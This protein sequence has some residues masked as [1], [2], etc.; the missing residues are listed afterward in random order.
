MALKAYLNGSMKRITKHQMVTFIGGVKKRIPKGVTFVNGQ[1]VVLWQV[2]NFEFNSWTFTELQCPVT[3]SYSTIYNAL[4]VNDTKIVYNIEKNIIRANI[5][6]VSS[7]YNENSVQY[8]LITYRQ[9]KSNSTNTYY[10]SNVRTTENINGTKYVLTCN[11]IDIALSD[12]SITATQT[13]RSTKTPTSTPVVIQSGYYTGLINVGGNYGMVRIYDN[14]TQFIIYK[15]FSLNSQTTVA[16]INLYGYSVSNV[17]NS[18]KGYVVY[19]GRY[20]L[21]PCFYK[22]T[23]DSDKVYSLKRIDLS[24]GNVITLID[25]ATTPITGI[26]IDGTNILVTVGSQM[27]KINISG[28]ELTTAYTSPNDLP[29]IV[30]KYGNYYYLT[31]TRAE[32]DADYM[33]IE[34]VDE[35]DFTSGEVKQTNVKM[36]ETLTMPYISENGYICFGSKFYVKTYGSGSGTV[37]P[38]ASRRA[39]TGFGIGITGTTVN[40]SNVEL[41]ICRIKCY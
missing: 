5:S 26:L 38:S 22:A 1:K 16:T 25:N 23:S 30:G 11:E 13:E 41:R 21:L 7:P 33:N 12:L 27:K 15:N 34:I 36:I 2:G 3:T 31:T 20:L 17:S 10:D 14:I 28:T 32:T 29:T 37:T 6:N 9:P 18:F 4:E 40:I 24:N 19:D 39:S 35:S 8:G